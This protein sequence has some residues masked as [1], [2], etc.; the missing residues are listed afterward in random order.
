[1][2]GRLTRPTAVLLTVGLVF[3][4]GAGTASAQAAGQPPSPALYNLYFGDL[5]AHTGYSDGARGS[6]PDDAF[7]G[8]ATEGADFMATTD[9]QG[10]LT[11]A[12]WADTL[13]AA[14]RHTSPTFVAMAGYEAWVV[15]IGEI[16]M[17][18]TPNWPK[19]PTGKGADKANSGHHGNRWL[20]LPETYDW[21]AAQPGAVGQW[22]HPTA[23]AGVSSENFVGFADRTLSRDGGMGLI[24]V[25]NDVV[26]ESSYVLALDAGWHVMPAANSDTHNPDWISGSEV[27]TVLL[28]PDLTPAALYGAMSAGR[29]YATVDRN[30]RVRFAV[31][32]AVMGSVLDGSTQTFEIRVQV[33]DPDPGE[34]DALTQVEIVSDGGVVVATLPAGG[35]EGE[36]SATLSSS[37]ARYYYARVSTASGPDGLPG[38]TAWT[39]PV[40]TG[41]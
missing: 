25:F 34:A 35:N 21:L 37:T 16:N 1:M 29:G 9:H 2:V 41:R 31:N 6:T 32:G 17:F 30:L 11:S 10:S 39:A 36:W 5:H 33:E 22:N 13:A 12:E 27:R 19:E 38:P 26:Y 7:S 28:A 3:T 14:G 23:Y 18:N 24:E 40:W 4:L 15:G 20:S 8:A